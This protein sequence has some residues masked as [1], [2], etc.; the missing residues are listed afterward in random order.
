[1]AGWGFA[2]QLSSNYHSSGQSV[3]ETLPTIK[4]ILFEIRETE[5]FLGSDL[6]FTVRV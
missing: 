5:V 3:F 2:E 6:N 1:M 4:T